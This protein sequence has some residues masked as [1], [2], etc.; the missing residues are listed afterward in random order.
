MGKYSGSIL[1]GDANGAILILKSEI[2]GVDTLFCAVS[3][4][5]MRC[6]KAHNTC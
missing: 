3:R 5:T 6:K 4:F 1:G 2:D